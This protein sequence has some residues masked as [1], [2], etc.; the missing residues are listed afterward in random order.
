VTSPSLHVQLD[1]ELPEEVAVGDGTA[2]FVCGWCFSP[3]AEIT[4]L[5]FV[6]NGEGQPVDSHAMPRLDPLRA[7]H[8]LHA[9]RSGFWGL[10]RVD[11]PA[12]DG[13]Y[14]LSLRATLEGGA[15]AEAELGRIAT[16]KAARPTAAAWP[17]GAAGPRVAIA[18]A[19]YD[20]PGDLLERQ[21][22][23]IRSQTHQNWICLISD[24][25]SRP[26]RFAALE[27]AIAGDERFV[28]S[29][30]P[31]RLG[32]YRNFERALELVPPD[33]EYVAMADQDDEWRPGK[34]AALLEQ[35]GDAQLIYSD[36]RVVSRDRELI[37]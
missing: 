11:G 31:R 7:V 2:I 20:P 12:A 18:M 35:I 13:S 19:T 16:A 29:R 33:A 9:Y 3:D 21:L 4:S 15:V 36:A 30:S 5:E 22:E 26:E 25:C 1:A 17:A 6:L 8:D 34:L 23:S 32:F 37:S 28:L 24:D 10:V 27:A 14:T